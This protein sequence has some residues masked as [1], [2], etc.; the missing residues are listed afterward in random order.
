MKFE[1]RES[2][3]SADA[4]APLGAFCLGIVSV[5]WRLCT[6]LTELN[7][8]GISIFGVFLPSA[9]LRAVSIKG[10]VEMARQAPEP[11]LLYRLYY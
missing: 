8:D 4:A 10:L 5:V 11:L 6:G 9:F 2:V 7:A 3:I 1:N